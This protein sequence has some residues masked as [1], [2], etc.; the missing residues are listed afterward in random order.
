MVLKASHHGDLT[1][2][3]GLHSGVDGF[4]LV[5]DFDGD[6]GVIGERTGLIHLSEASTAEETAQLVL[7][8]ESGTSRRRRERRRG[9]R[10]TGLHGGR[11]ESETGDY[12]GRRFCFNLGIGF[13]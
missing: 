2:N 7:A 10:T 9:G 11:S 5:D 13:L 3:A 1:D 6:N 8:K 4:V 12:R